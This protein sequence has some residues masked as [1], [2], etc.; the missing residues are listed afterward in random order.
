MGSES[1]RSEAERAV[2]AIS[3]RVFPCPT[4]LYGDLYKYLEQKK[5]RIKEK[6]DFLLIGLSPSYNEK[7]SNCA[8]ASHY[9]N[10]GAKFW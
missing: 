1:E 7:N 6:N 4:L 10:H 8:N 5:K 9:P 3:V 2:G